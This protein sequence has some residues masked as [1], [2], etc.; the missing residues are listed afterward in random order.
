MLVLVMTLAPLCVGAGMIPGIER[1][2]RFR[3]SLNVILILISAGL[4]AL[5]VGV[6]AFSV[7]L[8]SREHWRMVSICL[9]G[10]L[11]M[12][13]STV[14]AL[15]NLSG[16]RSGVVATLSIGIGLLHFLDLLVSL[17]IS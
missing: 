5:W 6:S 4:F 8:T 14:A 7:P 3:L 15:K 13:T 16:V 9:A 17:P 12:L 10:L 11:S 2:R 1:V